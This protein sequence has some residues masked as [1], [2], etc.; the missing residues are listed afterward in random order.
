MP[1]L[2]DQD[3]YKLLNWVHKTFPYTMKRW[4]DNHV[5]LVKD[6]ES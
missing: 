3:I 2:E 1:E 4:F 6:D 5:D